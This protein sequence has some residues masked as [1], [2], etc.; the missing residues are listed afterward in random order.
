MCGFTIPACSV[1]A[2]AAR[3]DK[4]DETRGAEGVDGDGDPGEYMNEDDSDDSVAQ[5]S[6]GGMPSV[7][8]PS[9]ATEGSV[10]GDGTAAATALPVPRPVSSGTGPGTSCRHPVSCLEHTRPSKRP[11]PS[12]SISVLNC[13]FQEDSVS[14]RAK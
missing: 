12:R 13:A 3:G 11:L 1:C 2:L 10:E 6:Q 7:Q 8:D 9:L 5:L 4:E 14:L